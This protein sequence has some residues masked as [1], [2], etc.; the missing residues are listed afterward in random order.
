MTITRNTG[1]VDIIAGGVGSQVYL[2]T[3]DLHGGSTNLVKYID[4]L[5]LAL[6]N[7]GAAQ[8]LQVIIKHRDDLKD[9]L[10]GEQA[11]LIATE[12]EL[13]TIRPQDAVYYRLR[14]QDDSVSVLWKLSAFDF[15]GGVVGDRLG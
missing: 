5:R 6:E 9:P 8:G 14:L 13:F 4:A 1:E 11:K 2:E 3:K 15:W 12:K 10:R 7:Q